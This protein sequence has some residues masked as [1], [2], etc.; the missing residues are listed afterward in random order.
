MPSC[1]ARPKARDAVD[2]A[3]IDRLG[4]AP[5][6]GVHALDGHAED[7]ARGQ[8]VD[9]DAFPEGLLQRLDLGHM[10]GEAKLDL[11]VVHRKQLMAGLGDEG[12]ADLAALLRAHRDVLQIGIVGGDAA[13]RCRGQ[14]EG[15]MDPAGRGIDLR[16]QRVGIGALELGELA[17]IEDPQ[18]QIMALG[19]QLLQH[20][21]AGRIGAGLA[22]LAAC[23]G[24][25]RRTAP[26]PAAWAS[27]Y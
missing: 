17:P 26:R 21:G 15:G 13:R 6:H 1:A 11:G 8:G 23:R 22:L 24:R 19:R 27:R 4:L 12:A 9:V 18:R 16:H 2:D 7:L 10:G 3:E 14:R 5:D 20:I 25:A